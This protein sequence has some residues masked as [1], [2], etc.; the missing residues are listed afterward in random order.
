MN[1]PTETNLFFGHGTTRP[2]HLPTDLIGH[3]PLDRKHHYQDGYSMAEAAKC[4][5]G[6]GGKLPPTLA[7]LVGSD[8]LITAH[9]EYETP[10]WGGGSS[11][12]DIMAFVPDS[13]IAVEAKAR[14]PF[15]QKVSDWIERER[16]RN[17][18]SPKNRREAIDRYARSLRVDS[19]MLLGIRYQLLHRTLSAALTARRVGATRAWMIVQSFSPLGCDEHVRNEG[20]YDRY[21][22]LVGN[23]PILE[24]VIVRLA[25][26]D[27]AQ[28]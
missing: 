27:E 12:T 18:R 28:D 9:F 8:T 21:L 3:L 19:Q 25:W 22:G 11:V 13:V 5:V 6:A 10:V 4:W 26:V 15:D 14:E 20:D 17:P 2:I 1:D 7:G 23:A 16:C 24:D